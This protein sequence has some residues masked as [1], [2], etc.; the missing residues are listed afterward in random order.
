MAGGGTVVG[1]AEMDALPDLRA[2]ANF[3]VG[4]DSVDVAGRRRR[5][6][7]VTN[8]P[9]VLTDEVADLAVALVL[10]CCAA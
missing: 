4:Y 10:A 6:I 9:D 2:V 5:G 3:G 7:V 1:A 8:T